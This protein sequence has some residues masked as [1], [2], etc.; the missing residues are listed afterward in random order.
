M[1]DLRARLRN[2][3]YRAALSEAQLNADLAQLKTLSKDELLDFLVE[4]SE[5]LLAM[6]EDIP[7]LILDGLENDLPTDMA[8]KEVAEA[9][10]QR[11]QRA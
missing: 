4:M 9:L 8:S 5:D 6:V 1:S 2:P 3:A 7:N 10:M 11:L